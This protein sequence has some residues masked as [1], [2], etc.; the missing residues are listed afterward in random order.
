MNTSYSFINIFFSVVYYILI[1]YVLFSYLLY[2]IF[3]ISSSMIINAVPVIIFTFIIAALAIN[4]NISSFIVPFSES[5]LIGNLLR[6]PFIISYITLI[7][8]FVFFF[9]T[10]VI[11]LYN[12][13][14]L[15]SLELVNITLL[16][17]SITNITLI[18]QVLVN[19]SN[20]DICNTVSF[21]NL[22]IDNYMNSILGNNNYCYSMVIYAIPIMESALSIIIFAHKEFAKLSF[23]ED[24]LIL[25]ILLILYSLKYVFAKIKLDY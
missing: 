7:H 8:I 10:K 18:N 9:F 21:L 3:Y 16:S 24:Y 2:Y 17:N 1:L 15:L 22:F 25:I 13:I 6:G 12:I 11:V 5:I 14:I 4:I 20:L 19:Y 23:V